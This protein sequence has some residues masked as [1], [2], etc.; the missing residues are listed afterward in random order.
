MVKVNEALL[1]KKEVS[2][3]DPLSTTTKHKHNNLIEK[4]V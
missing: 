2:P 3:G 4:N 1:I